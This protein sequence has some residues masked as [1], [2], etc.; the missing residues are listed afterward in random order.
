MEKHP[1]PRYRSPMSPTAPATHMCGART[2]LGG[3]GHRTR[4]ETAVSLAQTEWP[5]KWTL[6]SRARRSQNPFAVSK[7]I[8][9]FSNWKTEYF[10]LKDRS[11]VFLFCTAKVR[12][13][14]PMRIAEFIYRNV[15]WRHYTLALGRGATFATHLSPICKCCNWKNRPDTQ[16]ANPSRLDD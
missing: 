15:I 10:N 8:K 1:L 11:G 12:G 5:W 6:H 2:R 9:T 4:P 3:T 16:S 14:I 7:P 13:G